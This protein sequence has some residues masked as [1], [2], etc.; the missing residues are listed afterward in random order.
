MPAQMTITG[1]AVDSIDTAR[2]WMTL[3]PWPV[4]EDLAIALH[5]PIVGAGVVLGDPHQEAGD[6]EADQ[7]AAVDPEPAEGS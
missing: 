2:P 6:G 4:V 5:R 1:S 7:G 3:V